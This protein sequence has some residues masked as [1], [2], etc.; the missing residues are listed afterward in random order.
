[1]K[2]LHIE[3]SEQFKSDILKSD[4]LCLVDF[5]ADWCVP[6]KIMAPIIDQLAEETDLPVVIAKVNVDE[7][8]EVAT[9]YKIQSIPTVLFFQNGT[10]VNKSVGV[11]SKSV[12]EQM[13]QNQLN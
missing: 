11:R 1:M 12:L 3:S 13:I 2:V 7:C 4:R 5:W 8:Q 10:V 9:K 6:C